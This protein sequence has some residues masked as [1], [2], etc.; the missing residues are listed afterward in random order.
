M[1]EVI[2]S[3]QFIKEISEIYLNTYDILILAVVMFC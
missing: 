1:A 2:L 3:Q